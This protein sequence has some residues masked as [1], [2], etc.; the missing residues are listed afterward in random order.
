MFSPYPSTPTI[1]VISSRHEHPLHE[2]A[3]LGLLAWEIQVLFVHVRT[4]H[5][6]RLEALTLLPTALLES[7]IVEDVDVG[8]FEVLCLGD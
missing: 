4:K 3:V 2:G 1:K 8:A 6:V 7:H 5:F